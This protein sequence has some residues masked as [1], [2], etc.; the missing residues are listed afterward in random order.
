[1]Q[2]V[3]LSSLLVLLALAACAAPGQAAPKISVENAWARPA[4]AD[5]MPMESATPAMQD[6]ATTPESGATAMS[7]MPGMSAD[8]STSAAYFVIVNDGNEADTLVGVSSN[9]AGQAE[10]HQTK[11]E[12][13]IAQMIPVP[14]LAVPAH[15]KVE[16]AP[17]GY[18]VMLV[19]LTRDLNVGDTIQ[20]TLQ[21]E[22]SGAIT[23][24]VPVK[25]EN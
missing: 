24:D 14:Q 23:V 21:F 20:L 18:H 13:D 11:V 17:G 16:F 4:A 6:M 8:S 12:N 15:G 19:G 10:M 9:A 25:A 2:R 3:R 5:L 22:K 1:M 7:A